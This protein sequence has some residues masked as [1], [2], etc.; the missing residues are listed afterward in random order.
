MS[1]WQA[2]LADVAHVLALQN[3]SFVE[4]MIVTSP[5]APALKSTVQR[6]RWVPPWVRVFFEDM[7]R[8]ALAGKRTW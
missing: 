7:Q 5:Q 2:E 4:A 6:R 1:R 8:E 3:I